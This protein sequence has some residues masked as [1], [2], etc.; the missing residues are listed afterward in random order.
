MHNAFYDRVTSIEREQLKV[1]P[2]ATVM[3][4]KILYILTVHILTTHSRK[5]GNDYCYNGQVWYDQR[6]HT[7]SII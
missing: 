1:I 7:S 6:H 5:R 3:F 4:M 2:M